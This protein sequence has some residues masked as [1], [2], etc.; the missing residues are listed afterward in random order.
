MF[1]SI[2][3]IIIIIIIIIINIIVIIWGFVH[4]DTEYPLRKHAYS[5]I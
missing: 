3:F 4:L 1:K 2:M 5:N